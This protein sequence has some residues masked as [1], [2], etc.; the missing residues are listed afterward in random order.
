[1]SWHFSVGRFERGGRLEQTEP[2]GLEASYEGITGQVRGA[3][4]ASSEE[5]EEC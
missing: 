2:G 5:G 1:M 4:A 3:G